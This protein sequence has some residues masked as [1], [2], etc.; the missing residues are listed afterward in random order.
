MVAILLRLIWEFF[1]IGLFS[2]GGGLAVLVLLQERVSVLGWLTQAE[3]TDM[4]AISQ[5]TPGP[6]AINLATFVG[7]FK[8]GI[9]GSI[10]A[11]VSVIL[12]GVILSIIIGRFIKEFDEK[13][14]VKAILKGL[15]AMVIGLIAAAILNI[16]KV[17]ILD[18]EKYQMSQ[19]ILDLFDLKSILLFTIILVFDFKF[20]KHPVYYILPAGILGI[21]LWN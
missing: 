7:Y 6:I 13:P 1:V 16:A 5:S 10:L 20:K 19:K 3:F 12:P 21:L 11:S 14:I 8:G 2:Y 9:I 15:R 4:I 18:L 17:S